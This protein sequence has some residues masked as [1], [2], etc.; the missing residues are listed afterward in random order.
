MSPKIQFIQQHG[1]EI[2]TLFIGSS[3]VYHGVNPG[4]FDALTA[5]AGVP[6]HSYN[7]GVDAMLPPETFYLADQILATKPQKLRWVFIELEDIQV[8]ITPEHVRTQ[9]ALSWHDWKRTWLVA[10]KLLELDVRE[11]WKQKR[12][13][14]LR[15]REYREHSVRCGKSQPDRIASLLEL[16]AHPAGEQRRAGKKMRRSSSTNRGV[17][18]T[19]PRWCHWKGS[20]GPGMS[21][22]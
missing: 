12:N 10:R 2:D 16:V 20:G 9:R 8:T 3:R 11:K 7:F 13:R 5:A 21:S 19:R 4:V 18:A 1:D 22:G 17:M 6:T 14:L 15:N